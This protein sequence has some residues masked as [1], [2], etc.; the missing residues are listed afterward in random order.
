[1]EINHL[2]NSESQV[3]LE[4]FWLNH[5]QQR[6]Q[7]SLSKIAYCKKHG[8]TYNQYL[9]R[10]HKLSSR[11]NTLIKLV[12]VQIAQPPVDQELKSASE[13]FNPPVKTY[14]LCSL[15]L[16]NGAVLQIYDAAVLN[17]LIAILK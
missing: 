6:N 4:D 11:P 15:T 1:M 3:S 7:S 16:K 5:I 13:Q 8:L 10:E 12:P 2:P 17:T 14:V 9:Y